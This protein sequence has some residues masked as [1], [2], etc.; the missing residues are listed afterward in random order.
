MSTATALHV[1]GV[2]LTPWATAP[3]SPRKW[4]A[5]CIPAVFRALRDGKRPVITAVTGA[6]KSKALAEIVHIAAERCRGSADV[7]IVTTPT[8]ALVRQL[9]AT[10]AERSG[11][12]RVGQYY[13]D[14]KQDTRP[15]VVACNP[16]LPSLARRLQFAGRGCRLLLVDECHRSEAP[17]VR[18]SVP[19][20]A[21]R[22]IVGCTATPYRGTEDEGLSLFDA[23]A[24][25]YTLADA[26]RDGVLVPWRVVNFDGEGSD[27]ADDVCER[28]IRQHGAGPGVVSAQSIDDAEAYAQRLTAAGIPAEAIHSDLAA[29]EF[30]RRIEALRTGGLRCLVHVA[31]LVEGVDFPWLRWLCLRRS[32]ASA[33]RFVQEIG[34]VLRI[35][36]AGGKTHAVLMDPHDLFGSIGIAH[37]ERIGD[38]AAALDAAAERETKP[39]DGSGSGEPAEVPRA[40]VVGLL[41]QWARQASLALWAAGLGE[42]PLR[43][44][45]WRDGYP[46]PRQLAALE[47]MVWAARY[48]PEPSRS[49]IKAAARVAPELTAGGVSDVLSVL[50]AL[51]SASKT[52]RE[53]RR[54][55]HLPAEIE[56]P[57]V[58]E[59]AVLAAA[60]RGAA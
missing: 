58:S 6:G 38:A 53:Q 43:S 37:P 42:A 20:I 57:A 60:A 17:A 52:A 9:A 7:V 39:R 29:A 56:L 8:Q 24:Y 48:L 32:S 26:L 16:S 14:R 4:Q 2:D 50:S 33:I 18:E 23:V 10:L 46:T 1:P 31:M 5:E 44:R 40:V 11:A 55:F 30:A 47:R 13:A 25:R 12:D 59:A 41:S 34:R 21:P 19:R 3:W 28:M 15:I 27:E 51:A 54:H 35:D 22:F 36:P 45:A 49:A